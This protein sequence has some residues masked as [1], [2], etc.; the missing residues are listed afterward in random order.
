MART[1][2]P[3]RLR[4]AMR[5]FS[6]WITLACFG[7][8]LATQLMGQ[9][10]LVRGIGVEVRRDALDLLYAQRQEIR[11]ALKR[12][13]DA[14]ALNLIT[15]ALDAD[16][17]GRLLIRLENVKG[18]L[19]EGNLPA[20]PELHRT[21]GG[22][23]RFTLPEDGPDELEDSDFMRAHEGNYL[24]L[25]SQE[26]PDVRLL[27]GYRM[28]HLDALEQ[29]VGRRAAAQL[30]LALLLAILGS[31]AITTV[32][33]RRLRHLNHTCQALAEG[34]LQA[35][36]PT[37]GSGDEFDRL[38]ENF[39]AMLERIEGLVGAIRQNS[40]YLAH[41]LRTP[42]TRLRNLLA[43]MVE[44]EERAERAVAQIDGLS[45]T[46]DAILLLGRAEAGSLAFETEPVIVAP[47]L[48]GVAEMYEPLAEARGQ[49][50]MHAPQPLPRVAGQRQLL[51]QAVANLVDNAIKYTPQGGR[52]TLE[53]RQ[54][55]NA[56]EIGVT[57][58][59]P[60]IP[61][62]L[63]EKAVERFVRLDP[64]RSTPGTGLGLSLV[65][66]IARLHGGQLRLEEAETGGL[67]AMLVLPCMEGGME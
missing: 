26:R 9:F 54:N 18:E 7:I 23:E 52:I 49:M 41:D 43:P 45:A 14:H 36:A 25:L 38:S 27:I 6:F 31:L 59:G 33:L 67:R 63:R 50:L 13:Q 30:A 58:S 39:N 2:L 8:L 16:R 12:N 60:G 28:A 44:T 5:S 17:D 62:A 34:N 1:P 47:I 55:G 46:L 65:A 32:I 21:H 40:D 20:M 10:G 4:G 24:A 61:A 3:Q 53:A 64:S 15:A 19:L 11:S 56:I 37:R 35:R 22:I 29:S 57:D 66:A 51:A 42:L 48:E